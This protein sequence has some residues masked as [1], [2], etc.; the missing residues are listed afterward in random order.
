MT[1]GSMLFSPGNSERSNC[2]PVRVS[3]LTTKVVQQSNER[4][5]NAIIP[6]RQVVWLTIIVRECHCSPGSP[7]TSLLW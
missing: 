6:G 3:G 2:N 5:P 1:V 7:Q 4:A